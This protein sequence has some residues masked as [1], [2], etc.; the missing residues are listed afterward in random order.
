[1]AVKLIKKAL[2]DAQALQDKSSGRDTLRDILVEYSRVFFGPSIAEAAADGI[3]ALE[4]NWRG[5][6]KDNGA[7]ETGAACLSCRF[8]DFTQ[9]S[10]T[11][12]W[13]WPLR[14]PCR[15]QIECRTR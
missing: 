7:V 10:P 13:R 5:P 6:L 14:A 2:E 15:G 1:M 12:A 9:R 3:L 4:N 11:P 8:A